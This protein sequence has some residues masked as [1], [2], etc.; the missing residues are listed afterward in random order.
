MR[1]MFLS[2]V[3]CLFPGIA[4]ADD[5][6]DTLRFYLSQSDVVL[7]GEFTSALDA[8]TR[9]A[10]V[11]NYGGRFKIAEILK[12]D[13]LGQRRVGG[14]IGVCIVR[15]E[16]SPAD[17]LPELK[18]GGKCILFLKYH[19]QPNP[20]YITADM[21]FGI[22]PPLPKMAESLG[23]LANERPALRAS[24]PAEPTAEF[25]PREV[26]QAACNRL[27]A[28]EPQ[29]N[30]LK[31]VSAVTPQIELGENKR[32]TSAL[33]IFQQNAVPPGKEPAKAKD[34][35]RPFL[36]VSVQLWSGRSQQPPASVRE[37]E[38][39]GETYQ[40]WVQVYGSDPELVAALRQTVDEQI[41]AP[42]AIEQPEK[43]VL[44]LKNATSRQAYRSGQPLVFEGLAAVP[45]H[46]PGPE[47]FKITRMTD[48]EAIPFHANDD[49]EK[50]EKRRPN[51]VEAVPSRED[52]LVYN[53]L[54]KGTRLFLFRG[55]FDAKDPGGQPCILDLY[56][57][58]DL[59]LG[60]RYRVT[61][62]CWLVGAS[63][64]IETSCEFELSR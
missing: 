31:G 30:A 26:F 19:Q 42:P 15:F 58:P 32:L 23:R 27:K 22:Q 57:C 29:W 10:G 48:G 36:Y 40:A 35:S 50:V 1:T 41:L 28:L 3:I 54:F 2:L 46:R 39:K 64:A 4:L 18:Q 20:Y 37:F 62:A 49:R 33:F 17:R 25:D 56:G 38:W 59:E 11:I 12:G 7:L 44:R 24:P 45:I 16:G 51:Q 8:Y 14:T 47:H 9:E 63:K 21:W 13:V 34:A 53:S 6:D 60:V 55:N 52:I 5:G 61:W 43:P